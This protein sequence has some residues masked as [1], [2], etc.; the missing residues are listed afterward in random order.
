MA[1]PVKGRRRGVVGVLVLLLVVAGAVG[2]WLLA[3]GGRDGTSADPGPSDDEVVQVRRQDLT[4]GASLAGK[5]GYGPAEGVPIRAVGTV[6]WL[7]RSGVVVRRGGA[8]MRVDDKPVNLMYGATPAYR[9]LEDTA[10]ADVPAPGKKDLASGAMPDPGP[11]PVPLTGPDVAQ[12]EANLVAL[13]YGGFDPDDE[14][15]AATAAAVKAW[16]ADVGAPVTGRVVLGDVLFLP[17]P[18]R[19]VT[20]RSALGSDTPAAAVQRTATDK[21]V[22]VRAP[23]GS[24]EWAELGTRVKVT[25]P[26][27]RAVTATVRSVGRAP[28][29]GGDVDVRLE[30]K[31]P[32]RAPRAGAVTVSYVVE[33]RHDVLAV[34]VTALVA[35]AEGGYGV[36]LADGGGFVAVT[37]GLYADGEVEVTGDLEAGTRIRVPR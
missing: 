17:G 18:I 34:P 9:T 5:I 32:A 27:Q 21:V 6:T 2:A 3:Q 19:L 36:Q 8:V 16:Q 25:L 15:T 7:P 11:A 22:T 35:L 12:L 1:D 30:L 24:V 23:A 33:E 20:D 31:N 13:G 29:E 26:D 37:P 4:I 14:F 28:D 10:A